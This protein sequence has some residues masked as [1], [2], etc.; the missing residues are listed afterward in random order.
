MSLLVT[1]ASPCQNCKTRAKCVEVNPP[2]Q[3]HS[4][5]E[6]S[7]CGEIRWGGVLSEAVQLLVGYT[8]GNGGALCWRCHRK[9]CAAHGMES[10]LASQANASSYPNLPYLSG[11]MMALWSDAKDALERH[12]DECGVLV[13]ANC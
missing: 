7:Y 10:T 4:G 6:C 5:W 12:C 11:F 2:P 9:H 1:P 8:F 3:F 13:D